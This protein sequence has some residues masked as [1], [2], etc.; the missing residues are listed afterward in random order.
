[1]RV[2][3]ISTAHDAS[4]AVYCDGEIE[5]FSKE[6]RLTRIKRDKVP[7]AS[8]L[9]AAKFIDGKQVDAVAVSSPRDIS[10][11]PYNL[12]IIDASR[13]MFKANNV[14]H[15]A[16]THHLCHASLAFYDSGF[17]K[18]LVIVIDRNGSN[19][20][21]SRGI[22]FES[23]TVFVAEYPSNFTEIGKNYWAAN[24]GE[25]ADSVVM[26]IILTENKTKPHCT[27]TCTSSY[28]I[29]KVYETATVLI[30]ENI[31]ENGKTMGLAAYGEENQD[32]PELFLPN[33]FPNDCLFSH[34]K[35]PFDGWL[36]SI[37]KDYSDKIKKHPSQEEHKFYADYAY[38]VQKQ[39]QK[40]VL[41]II[42]QAISK[43]GIKN[44]CISGG[45]G[46]N[47]VANGYYISQLPDVNF[48]FEP[49]ADDTGNSIGAAMLVYRQLSGDKNI[50]PLK[51]TFFNGHEPDINPKTIDE[52]FNKFVDYKKAKAKDIA[53]LLASNRKVA[54]FDGK[55]EGGPRALGNRSI[56][57]YPNLADSK[58]IV[59]RI[60][61]REWYRPFAACVLK[62]D[63]DR[64][65]DMMTVG[66]SPYMTISFD[67]L[68]VT[69]AL[70][71]GIVHVDGSCRVQTV[72]EDN[73][74][75]Y[76]LLREVKKETR[77]GLLLNTSFNLAGSPLVE[78]LN[79][80]IDVLLRSELEYVWTPSN[81]T[82]LYKT[83]TN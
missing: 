23:E 39:T 76:E 82:V 8:M 77:H 60:K 9:E 6:E 59:N 55:S 73:K 83:K 43:T 47:V 29:T 46:L 4:V 28:G 13:K 1:M 18:A 70:F 62:E 17:D 38:Q 69:K 22:M 57:F 12:S 58:D 64:Y 41:E 79:E 36:A 10:L 15:L 71:P 52:T 26:E 32:F 50:R 78:T 56:L 35:H 24:K 42:K 74:N 37:Y 20:P 51:S 75:L 45:Y 2:V 44:V 21:D 61:N 19:H 5:F 53:R 81:E 27:T 31:L 49:L 40:Q 25:H 65:F 30:G 11:D 80:A 7:F 66:E 54:I 34:I 63:A 16:N 68:D 3:G 33:G 14:Q 72:D 67:C 48:F